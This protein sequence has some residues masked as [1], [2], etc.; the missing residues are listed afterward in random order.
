MAKEHWLGFDLGGTKMLAAVFDDEFNCLGR[1]RRRTH[2]YR[3]AEV[4]VER[5]TQTIQQ[6]LESCEIEASQLSGIGIGCPSPVDMRRGV[7]L[8]AANLGWE[9]VPLAKLLRSE[10]DSPVAVLNDVDAG[11]YGEFRFG[12]GRDVDSM[13][14]IFPGTGIGGGF[15]HEGE[16]LSGGSSSAME[17][18]HVCVDPRGGVCGCGSRGCLET[19]ASRLAIAA[20]AAKAALRG[21]APH[22]ME[23]AGADLTNIRSGA[24][25]ESIAAGDEV[26]KQIVVDAAGWIGIAAANVVS[27]LLPE[28]I[29]LGGGLVEAMPDLLVAEVKRSARKTVLPAFRDRFK[30][31]PA[32]LGDDASI[33]GAAGWIERIEKSK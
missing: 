7:I 3:G 4:G 2:G 1:K 22:L 15:V 6:A 13:L 8:D 29:L 33:M 14:G 27:L 18:G 31:A 25:A 20:E 19:V 23:E 5:I 9:D 16:I 21:E 24:I 32:E 17:I 26:V 11:V 28:M 12:A 10:F 30:V